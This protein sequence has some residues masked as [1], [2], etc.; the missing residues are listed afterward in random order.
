MARQGLGLIRPAD[1][2][3][4]SAETSS[5]KNTEGLPQMR[6]ASFKVG[7]MRFL[8]LGR[9]SLSWCYMNERTYARKV[10]SEKASYR[11]TTAVMQKHP[12][13]QLNQWGAQSL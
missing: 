7:G 10:A 9:L 11:H 4:W 12:A 3:T 8:Q 5:D 6:V 1:D 2:G 13:M